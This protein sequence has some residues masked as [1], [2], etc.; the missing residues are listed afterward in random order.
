MILMTS[1]CD[2]LGWTLKLK[3]TYAIT[4]FITTI[5]FLMDLDYFAELFVHFDMK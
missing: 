3:D 1:Y 4:Y 5:L 2:D